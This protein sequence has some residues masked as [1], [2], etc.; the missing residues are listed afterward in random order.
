MSHSRRVLT[1]DERAASAAS[2]IAMQQPD[3]LI[4]WMA[5]GHADPWNH[6]ESAMALD[7]V[8]HTDEARWAFAWLR[9]H[10]RADG[11]WHQYYAAWGVED[12]KFDANTIAYVAVGVMHH[13]L[14][15]SDDAWLRAQWSMVAQAIDFVL[16]L[17]QPTGEVFWA[18]EPDGTPFHYALVTGSSSICHSLRCAIVLAKHLGEETHRLEDA[19]DR[20]HRAL[21]DHERE[22][23]AE[24]DRWAM[25]WYYPVLSGVHS[26]DA[27]RARLA[28]SWDRFVLGSDGVRCVDDHP[29]VTTGE[30]AEAAIACWLAGMCNEAESLLRSCGRLRADDGSYFTGLHVPSAEWFPE[31]ERT[32]YS[33]AAV[34][35]ADALLAGDRPT[36]VVFGVR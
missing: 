10:Q 6:V 25:D 16:T 33:T 2:I 20:L 8:G 29:W 11:S 13:W 35:L 21:R 18:L 23:F 19:Y 9:D 32:T 34:V 14:A 1:A 5:G 22:F 36:S 28:A 24:K 7:V 3:G 26:G 30:T 4:L 27:A 17:Q 12:E 15:T 31:N